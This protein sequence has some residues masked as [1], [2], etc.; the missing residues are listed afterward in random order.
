MDGRGQ[1][2]GAFL[3]VAATLVA[4]RDARGDGGFFVHTEVLDGAGTTIEQAVDSEAISSN[5]QRALLMRADEGGC[6][7]LF[8]EPG[9]VRVSGAA[10]LLPVPVAPAS[11][12]PASP[13]LLAE[14]EAATRPIERRVTAVS[15]AQ[16]H[17][18]GPGEGC[19]CAG[20]GESGA[21]GDESS[22]LTTEASE[23]VDD[24]SV[25]LFGAGRVGGLEW[26]TL[27]A[28]S[29]A[30]LVRWLTDH[31]YAVPEGMEPVA[32][33]YV[34]EGWAFLATRITRA[35]DDPDTVPALRLELCT[36]SD[37][38]PTYPM[39]LTPF[40]TRGRLEFVLFVADRQ[41]W[42]LGGP[43]TA[44][45]EVDD[46]YGDPV[47][48]PDPRQGQ[49]DDA[50]GDTLWT[51]RVN[52]AGA[53]ACDDGSDTSTAEPTPNLE[54]ACDWRARGYAARQRE[55][56]AAQ[57]L[58]VFVEFAKPLEG[59]DVA[60][61]SDAESPEDALAAIEAPE[62]RALV[63]SGLWVARYRGSATAEGMK[64][65]LV[66]AP[67]PGWLPM[68]GVFVETCEVCMTPAQAELLGIAGIDARPDGLAGLPLVVFAC[69]GLF[70]RLRRPR[71]G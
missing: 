17:V 34:S 51:H 44:W 37:W 15:T 33:S 24:P 53:Y 54:V 55:E 2:V 28:E 11:V 21:G 6:W 49:R 48:G 50:T 65:D 9:R 71:R 18:E 12:S 59:A 42:S 19:F 23:G 1:R 26:Q 36:P 25:T 8:V 64:S 20:G 40:S 58:A 46:P 56:L 69:A 38:A 5:G 68:S 14:L 66:A 60:S 32:E 63:D 16:V 10:W 47:Y 43:V 30:D 3:L 22:L 45:P 13:T 41:R 70:V 35:A 4:A 27:A 67:L 39:R 57:D 29:G 52:F 31:G 61:R 62:L 7:S